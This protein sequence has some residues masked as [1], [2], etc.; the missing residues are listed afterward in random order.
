MK[1]LNQF[2]SLIVLFFLI[3]LPLL[4]GCAETE[5]TMRFPNTDIPESVTVTLKAPTDAAFKLVISAES[6]EER[7]NFGNTVTILKSEKEY[8]VSDGFSRTFW[9]DSEEPR[10]SVELECT[11]FGNSNEKNTDSL[12]LIVQFNGE[13]N[14]GRGN[15][16]QVYQ[17]K[18]GTFVSVQSSFSRYEGISKR[19]RHDT[20]PDESYF[21]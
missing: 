3:K 11:E 6:R 20:D 1:K 12:R 15:H 13:G 17:F 21:D 5:R 19:I 4:T 8:S 16:N 7:D 14:F 18:L 10:F 9:F 2:L